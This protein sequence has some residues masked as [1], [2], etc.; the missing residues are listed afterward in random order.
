MSNCSPQIGKS[1]VAASQE[2]SPP[3][4]SAGREQG[5]SFKQWRH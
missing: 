1:E 5:D 2:T 4:D 3:A